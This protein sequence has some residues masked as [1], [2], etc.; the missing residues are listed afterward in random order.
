MRLCIIVA[1]CCANLMKRYHWMNNS[2]HVRNMPCG[3]QSG[4]KINAVGD[5]NGL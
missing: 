1:V 3:L 4:K 5:A 2:Q